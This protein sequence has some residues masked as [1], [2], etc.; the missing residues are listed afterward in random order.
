MVTHVDTVVV[1]A[2]HAGLAVSRLLTS[3]GRDHVVLERGRVAESW[4]TER[5]ESLRLL[6]PSWM[7]R[8][9]GWQYDGPDRHGY[10]TVAQLVG[11]LEE[12]AAG[13]PVETGTPVHS[14]DAVGDGYR[15]VTHGR[16]WLARH[17]VVAT[18]ATGRPA[19]PAGLLGL[20]P[21]IEVVSPLGYR[22]PDALPPGGVLVVGASSSGVQIA[23][24]L[25]LAG[26]RVVL[27][28]GSHTRMPRRYR[29]ID[30]Y[31]W[32]E[33]T[34]RLSRT[35]D[36]MRDR[37]AARHEPSYQVVGRA[38]GDSRPADLDLARLQALGV[39]L[40]G[41]FQEA[42]GFRAH[43]GPAEELAANVATADRRMHRFLD[44]AD[45]CLHTD[46]VR[47][48]L[49]E[50]P[51]FPDGSPARP[52]PVRLGAT[53][54]RVGLWS[55]GISTIVVATGYRPHHPW[56]RV[57]VTE[58]DGSI[59]Q[60]RGATPAPGLYV[61]GQ[62]FQ[63]RRDSATLDGARHIARDVVDHLCAEDARCRRAALYEMEEPA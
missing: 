15:V 44:I 11:H 28:V 19:M 7:C 41:R 54:E 10:M 20:D 53:R 32:L 62:R 24:E 27:S 30:A 45:H 3:A 59:R 26:R 36:T 46:V 17:V 5:W 12:Y 31:W 18:G 35:I 23:E 57:P 29:G 37:V 63:H 40:V 21:S 50:W 39:E 34:G 33:R 60:V 52:R 51:V 42:D 6:A 9:P 13:V 8:L 22:R 25:A 55:E 4:R 48:R 16:T 2:G 1:G 58:P 47:D 56:L 14:V 61:V 43:F 49:D 38:P